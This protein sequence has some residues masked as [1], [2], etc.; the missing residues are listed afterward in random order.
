MSGSVALSSSGNA[1]AASIGV[2]VAR[3]FIGDGA[4]DPNEV[5][6]YI[7]NSSVDAGGALTQTATA[8]QDIDVG[9]GAG[10]VAAS[11]GN[12]ALGLSGAGV[13]TSNRISEKVSAYI[14]GDGDDGIRASSVTL[15]AND[16]SKIDADAGAASIAAAVSTS[17]NVGAALSVAVALAEND[18]HNVVES[19]IKSADGDGSTDATKNTGV[20]TAAGGDITVQAF[21]A[22]DIEAVAAYLATL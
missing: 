20:K 2:S 17:G 19:Y 14:D 7:Q 15:T 10:S 16:I 3:N 13:Q 22:A 1:G 5:Q 4:D 18:I 9:V 12:N 11:G 8:N 6:A 21:E